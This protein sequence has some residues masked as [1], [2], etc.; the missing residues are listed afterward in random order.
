M[1][2]AEQQRYKEHHIHKVRDVYANRACRCTS[3]SVVEDVIKRPL[4]TGNVYHGDEVPWLAKHIPRDATASGGQHKR[5]MCILSDAIFSDERT[6]YMDWAM[7][8]IWDPE[9][10]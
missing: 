1:S 6:N 4:E 7:P 10:K 9:T 3:M 2:D 8:S 5:L